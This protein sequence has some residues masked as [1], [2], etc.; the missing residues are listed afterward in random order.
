MF[1]QL[2]VRLDRQEKKKELFSHSYIL[3]EYIVIQ[4]G[5][6]I[7]YIKRSH[8]H[9]K[10]KENHQMK[11]KKKSCCHSRRNLNN[12][13]SEEKE[14]ITSE[15]KI[16]N[17]R[18][19]KDHDIIAMKSTVQPWLMQFIVKEVNSNLIMII[20]WDFEKNIEFQMFQFEGVVHRDFELCIT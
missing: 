8:L 3:S 15:M 17:I 10:L 20:T 1:D 13:V 16:A 2:Q 18:L 6:V 11:N 19:S 7:K 12:V 5:N 4:C 14:D 9:N